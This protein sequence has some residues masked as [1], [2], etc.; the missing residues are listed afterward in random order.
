[1][2]LR[3][4]DIEYPVDPKKELISETDVKGNITYANENFVD[5]S[6]Y[7]E[8]ELVGSPHSLIRH[9]D[10]PKTVFKLLW[11]NLLAGK[12]YKAIV[13]NKRKDGKYYWVYSTY[14]VLYDKD[15]KIRGFRSKRHPVPKKALEEVKAIYQKLLALEETKGQK[16]AEEFLEHKLFND[17]Y[18]DYAEYVEDIYNTKLKGL[19]GFLGKLFGR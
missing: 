4:L 11:D 2:A 7:S 3:P 8:K 18:H 1:M 19:F 9:V 13:Q 5:L 12:D 15:H 14:Q 6:G 16:G 10:M 17:G